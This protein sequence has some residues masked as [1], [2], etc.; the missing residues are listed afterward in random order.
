MR[1]VFK[2]TWSLMTAVVMLMVLAGCH[3]DDASNGPSIPDQFSSIIEHF[4]VTDIYGGYITSHTSRISYNLTVLYA[5]YDGK[6]MRLVADR[7]NQ[8]RAEEWG[9]PSLASKRPVSDFDVSALEARRQK[10]A[11]GR[12]DCDLVTLHFDV[13]VSG[14]VLEQAY[15]SPVGRG[16]EDYIV[17]SSVL[18]GESLVEGPDV[19]NPDHV[20]QLARVYDK[21]LP[22]GV[23]VDW[24]LSF[25]R[26]EN[27]D[28]YGPK[29]INA[30]GESC[31]P[32]M[33]S[34][35][36]EITTY[37]VGCG[38]LPAYNEQPFHLSNFDPNLVN[39]VADRLAEAG[40]DINQAMTLD[41][42]SQDG[43]NLTYKLTTLQASG[44][45]NPATTGTIT[46][47]K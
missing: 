16:G 30:Q 19:R 9:G 47:T 6:P 28:A 25:G 8:L 23:M 35:A 13:S 32:T 34:S 15:C 21:M 4:H 27:Q 22:G 46:P 3:T 26:P 18:D 12:T 39:I 44:M 5:D 24:T 20:A 37:N 10:L 41:F 14:S 31:M 7:D 29:T 1:R 42:Y 11:E 43:T 2:S 36:T 38:G 40:I 45:L 33:R 17:G